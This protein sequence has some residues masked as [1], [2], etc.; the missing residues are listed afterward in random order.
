MEFS[1]VEWLRRRVPGRDDLVVGLGDDA[2]VLRWPA[3]TDCAVTVD[4]LMDQ[5]DFD[6][7][8]IDPRRAGR[9]ALAVNLSDLAAMAARP[10]AAVIGLVL[11]IRGGERLGHALYE[12][13][14][15]LAEQFDVAVMGGDVN[16]WDGPLVISVT[17]LGTA[18][19]AGVWKRSGAKPGDWIVVTGQFGGSILGHHLDFEPR[20]REA[21]ALAARYP[22]RVARV[23]QASSCGYVLR[24]EAIPISPAAHQLTNRENDSATAL[25]HAL[26]D[27][28][29]FE[30]A[31][32]L[33]P[34]DAERL[35][36]D[37]PLRVQLT[38]I[39]EFTGDGKFWLEHRD[40]TR[41]ALTPAGFEHAF[42]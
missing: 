29:D 35:L 27:G 14:L 31:L 3:D 6:L 1:F 16:S 18:P 4:V 7:R 25:E 30:L 12:G 8:S 34:E 28:E 39:G 33:A 41:E 42:D 26:Q 38:H 21:L 40:G 11:P 9:K 15:P 23:A 19:L 13:M 20:V 24:Q 22:V 5:V 17:L 10:T 2:G 32:A 37:R 36:T